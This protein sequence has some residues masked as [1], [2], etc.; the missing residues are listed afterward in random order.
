M[1]ILEGIRADQIAAGMEAR[2]RKELLARRVAQE[3]AARLEATGILAMLA[4]LELEAVVGRIMMARLVPLGLEVLPREVAS[5]ATIQGIRLHQQQVSALGQVLPL[6]PIT[7]ASLETR[8]RTEIL[9]HQVE[10]NPRSAATDPGVKMVEGKEAL[11]G[12]AHRIVGRARIHRNQTICHQ[13]PLLSSRLVAI[14]CLG[15]S[16]EVP[17]P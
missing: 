7:A 1:V 15:I 4:I 11:A 6:A 8:N 16:L 3:L 9:D 2:N 17:P 12:P 14:Q 10:V 5:L 13:L